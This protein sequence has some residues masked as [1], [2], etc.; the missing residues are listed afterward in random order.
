MFRNM[1]SP[2]VKRVTSTEAIDLE[3][4]LRQAVADIERG[5]CLELTADQLENWAD[6]GELPWPEESHD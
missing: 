4:E 6:T 5:D 3:S 1:S 2:T